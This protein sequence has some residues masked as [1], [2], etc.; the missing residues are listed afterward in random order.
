MIW[1]MWLRSKPKREKDWQVLL[2]TSYLTLL[3]ECLG[4][5]QFWNLL[6]NIRM[7]ARISPSRIWS[8]WTEKTLC[9]CVGRFIPPLSSSSFFRS[10]VKAM[11]FLQDHAHTSGIDGQWLLLIFFSHSHT[12]TTSIIKPLT[13]PR[14]FLVSNLW[15]FL[16]IISQTHSISI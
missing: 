7:H 15:K 5:T 12:Y 11:R 8:W 4:W 10:V 13:F 16:G 2:F 1:I 9:A 6:L 14:S 3:N